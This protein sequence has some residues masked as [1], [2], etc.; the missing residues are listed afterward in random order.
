MS[1][2]VFGAPT[3]PAPPPPEL[4]GLPPMPATIAIDPRHLLVLL[5]AVGCLNGLIGQL[6]DQGAGKAAVE[7]TLDGFIGE[8]AAGGFVDVT[9]AGGLDDIS[10]AL[11]D[12][13]VAASESVRALL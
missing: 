8:L 6:V 12:A 4:P 7:I 2:T 11:A 1:E 5:G 10:E 9:E 13:M 3:P